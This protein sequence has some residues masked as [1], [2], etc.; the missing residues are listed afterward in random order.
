MDSSD[1]DNSNESFTTTDN[2]AFADV[3][4]SKNSENIV[5]DTQE[6]K[7]AER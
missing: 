6:V 3:D 5:K 2:A 1:S 4:E 7:T